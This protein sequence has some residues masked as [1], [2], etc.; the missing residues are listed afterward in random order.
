MSAAAIW[1]K[2]SRSEP[3]GSCVEVAELGGRIGVRDNKDPGGPVLTF[4]AWAWAALID[5]IKEDRIS[6]LT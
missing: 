2:S 1:R 3:D 4:S 6:P 5:S